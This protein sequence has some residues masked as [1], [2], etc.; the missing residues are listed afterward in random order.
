MGIKTDNTNIHKTVFNDTVP[1]SV[2]NQITAL[3]SESPSM[4][5]IK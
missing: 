5:M 1:V 3:S 2:L 4:N